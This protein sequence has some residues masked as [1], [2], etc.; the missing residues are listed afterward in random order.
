VLATMNAPSHTEPM[1]RTI[2][3]ARTS[4]RASAGFDDAVAIA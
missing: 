1:R 4:Q 3:A 2:C